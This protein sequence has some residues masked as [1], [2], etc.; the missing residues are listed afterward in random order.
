MSSP[1]SVGWDRKTKISAVGCKPKV[2]A[3]NSPLSLR[4]PARRFAHPSHE[5]PGNVLLTP[6]QFGAHRGEGTSAIGYNEEQSCTSRKH[7]H[8]F[9]VCC[10]Y[11]NIEAFFMYTFQLPK[12]S[13]KFELSIIGATLILK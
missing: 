1:N 9:S 13:T 2:E 7:S 12:S 4:P 3:S 5:V 11:L 6:S 8:S 10:E